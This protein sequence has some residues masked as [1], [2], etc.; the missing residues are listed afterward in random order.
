MIAGK[1]R[2]PLL[3]FIAIGV[4]LASLL[5]FGLWSRSHSTQ[6]STGAPLHDEK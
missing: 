2:H 4:V 5:M 6:P 3:F 1:G